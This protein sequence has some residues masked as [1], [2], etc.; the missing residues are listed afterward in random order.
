MPSRIDSIRGNGVGELVGYIG[1]LARR[2]D[3]HSGGAAAR[4]ERRAGYRR[5]RA[6]RRVDS[7]GG[8]IVGTKVGDVGELG[9]W[10]DAHSKGIGAC[11]K[12]RPL[13]LLQLATRGIDSI[14]RNIVEANIGNV[15]EAAPWID[16]DLPGVSARLCR[17]PRYVPIQPAYDHQKNLYFLA[18]AFSAPRRPQCA[19]FRTGTVRM[20]R[21]SYG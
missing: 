6:G 19:R 17:R 1:E 5:Q 7:V 9:R 2:I 13:H 11:G 15:G 10:I 3:G 14:S 20:I 12:E 16:D 4:L 21:R 8:N 18:N